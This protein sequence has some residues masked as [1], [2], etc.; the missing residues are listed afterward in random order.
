M[1][2]STTRNSHL[3][4]VFF[5]RERKQAHQERRQPIRIPI[6]KNLNWISIAFPESRT[7]SEK[8]TGGKNPFIE[9]EDIR[10]KLTDRSKSKTMPS[11]RRALLKVIILGDSGCVSIPPFKFVYRLVHLQLIC[12]ETLGAWSTMIDWYC[13]CF[14]LLKNKMDVVDR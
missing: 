8:E 1:C 13:C 9:S 6:Q 4:T 5:S 10:S 3:P 2:N 12:Y 14:F 11:R 7:R